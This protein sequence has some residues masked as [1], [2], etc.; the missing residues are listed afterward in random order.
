LPTGSERQPEIVTTS[1]TE[2]LVRYMEGCFALQRNKKN[3]Q[4]LLKKLKGKRN[5]CRVKIKGILNQRELSRTH[6]SG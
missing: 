4:F 1:T 6:Q 2:D 5:L 3:E